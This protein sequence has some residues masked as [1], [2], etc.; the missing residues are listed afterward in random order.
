MNAFSRAK[1]ITNHETFNRIKNIVQ[2]FRERGGAEPGWLAEAVETYLSLFEWLA[3]SIDTAFGRW[4][5][6]EQGLKAAGA[7]PEALDPL[8][9]GLLEELPKPP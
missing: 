1:A 6:S 5:E 2:C 3:F 7:G 8:W 4:V 9:R